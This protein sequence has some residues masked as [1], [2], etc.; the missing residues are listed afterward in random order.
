MSGW[1]LKT[2]DRKRLDNRIMLNA[3]YYRDIKN[4]WFYD[5]EVI[6]IKIIN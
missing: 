1:F 4:E 2:K 5:D 6:F 3:Y